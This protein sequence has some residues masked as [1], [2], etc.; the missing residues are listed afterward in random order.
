[1][2]AEECERM[3]ILCER[4]VKEKDLEKF[5]ELVQQVHDLLEAKERRLEAEK[6]SK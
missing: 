6:K 3:S 2:T 5:A 4:I 1:M